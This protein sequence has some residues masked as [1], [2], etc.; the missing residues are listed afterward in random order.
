MNSMTYLNKSHIK[1][2][3][4]ITVLSRRKKGD[5][6]NTYSFS[7]DEQGNL[8]LRAINQQEEAKKEPAV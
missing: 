2:I 4:T 5:K 1:S 8:H 6:R 7:L 3:N